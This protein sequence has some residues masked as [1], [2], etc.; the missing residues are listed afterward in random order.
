VVTVLLVSA[1]TALAGQS[2]V[3]LRSDAPFHAEPGGTQLGTLQRGLAVQTGRASGGWREVTFEA[4]IW[5]GSLGP[6]NRPGFTHQVQAAGGEN[7]RVEPNG[8]VVGRA[9]PGTQLVQ[10]QRQGGWTRV[11]RTAWVP[12]AALGESGPGEARAPDTIVRSAPPIA[13]L[14]SPG[15]PPQPPPGAA[16]E[17]GEPIVVRRGAPL[18]TGPGA[19]QVGVTPEPVAGRV[20]ARQGNWVRVRTETWVR[21][22]D[23]QPRADSG[24]LTLEQLRAD[25]EGAV[26]RRVSWRLQFLELRQADELRPELGLGEPYVLARGPLPEA[27]FVYVAVSR[28]QVERFRR[29]KPLDEFVAEA[30]I[31]AARTRFLPTPVIELVNGR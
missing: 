31:R 2:P 30:V 29:M 9:V 23:V 12:G 8:A 4:W 6:A 1:V 20:T 5:T 10:V 26:G 24:S 18:Y 11:R 19:A 28:A 15:S 3:S 17:I 14:G 25:P 27:G 21:E 22:E 13:P 7:F 16:E